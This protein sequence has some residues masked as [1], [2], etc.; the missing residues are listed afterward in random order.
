M[1]DYPI[2]VPSR[3]RPHLVNGT[4]SLFAAAGI[5]HRLVVE[6]HEVSEYADMWGAE[7]LLVLPDVGRGIAFAR[8]WIK[9]HAASEGH[10][11]HWQWDDNI[12]GVRCWN[13]GDRVRCD[14]ASAMRSASILC[15]RFTNVGVAGLMSTAFGH[16]I[17]EPF[18]V[19]QQVYCAMLVRDGPLR[20]RSPVGIAAE[21]TDYSLQVLA[22]GDCTII[23]RAFQIEKAATGSMEGGND[24][25]YSDDG[26]LKRAR[27]LQSKWGDEIV[28]VTRR[29]G[30]VHQDLSH[31]WRRFNQ[32]LEPV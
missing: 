27:W 11:R 13:G 17:T 16:Q 32:P 10:D 19:N 26:R 30:R 2:Y 4:A 12:H 6:S 14:P 21:D 25:T 29:N 31:V 18:S 24:R 23:F 9:D 15:D 7:N 22:T 3:G 20:F 8:N 5:P 1:T 28:K